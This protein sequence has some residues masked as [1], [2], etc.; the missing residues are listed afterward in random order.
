MRKPVNAHIL[1][2]QPVAKSLFEE[3]FRQRHVVVVLEALNGAEQGALQR[4]HFP[5]G[6][7]G[8]RPSVGHDGDFVQVTVFP[9]RKTEY[10]ENSRGCHQQ[11]G[12]VVHFGLH[13]GNARAGQK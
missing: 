11:A 7:G 8:Q 6:G 13:P 3:G 10:G 12:G 2:V 5:V 9:A 4:F 1:P